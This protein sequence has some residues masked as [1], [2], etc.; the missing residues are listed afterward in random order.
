[1]FD[2]FGSKRKA[3][4][5]LPEFQNSLAYA[6]DICALIHAMSDSGCILNIIPVNK[7]TV[8]EEYLSLTFS[9]TLINPLLRW[10]LNDYYNDFCRTRKFHAS[11]S[12]YMRSN[13]SPSE[14]EERVKENNHFEDEMREKYLSAICHA[15]FR[16]PE[17]MNLYSRYHNS[18]YFD[19]SDLLYSCFGIENDGPNCYTAS[20]D[21]HI[22]FTWTL[23]FTTGLSNY[24]SNG[25][26]KP[27]SVRS[28]EISYYTQIFLNELNK[29]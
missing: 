12:S 26:L 11:S 25:K 8:S 2:L 24:S 5:E 22:P 21:E 16:T 17:T 28:D 14:I 7:D 27:Q 20:D 9:T 23:V 1:M 15:L 6:R 18:N 3:I 10:T 4:L 19:I 29:H 13:L